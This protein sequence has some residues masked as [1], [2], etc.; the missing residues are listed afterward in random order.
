MFAHKINPRWVLAAVLAFGLALPLVRAENTGVAAPASQAT[1]LAIAEVFKLAEKEEK[2]L[3]FL[4]VVVAVSKVYDHDLDAMRL[5]RK[6]DQFAESVKQAVAQAPDARGKIAAI[7]Q[8][9]YVDQGF[10]SDPALGSDPLSGEGTLDASLLHRVVERKTGICLGLATVYLVVCERAN[11]PVY[12]V[13]APNHIFCRWDDGASKFNIE[14][15][16]RGMIQ[17]DRQ[18]A[19]TTHATKAGMTQSPYFRKGTKKEVLSDQLNNLTYDL[20]MRKKGPAPFTWAQ[21][22]K[23]GDLAAKLQPRSAEV[24]DTAACIQLRAG[25]PV[26]ALAYSDQL[27]PL[28]REYGTMPEVLVEFEKR[29]KEYE[30]AV[31]KQKVA[32]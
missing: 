1:D 25:N 6:L 18:I 31:Q 2:N 14:C 20:A 23:L 3:T 11:L 29:H 27:V 15:T 24:L 17:S 30:A 26:R 21:L 9:L 12:P 8:V 7:N 32:R 16:A 10:K 19:Q 13:H 22:V 5:G 4:E 28:A